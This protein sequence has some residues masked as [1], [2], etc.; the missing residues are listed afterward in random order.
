[1]DARLNLVQRD[2]ADFHAN[3]IDAV[4]RDHA[5]GSLAKAALS[6]TEIDSE[7]L[8]F[9]R[10]QR[11]LR[12]AGVDQHGYRATV[13]LALRHKIALPICAQT[14]RRRSARCAAAEMFADREIL[15]LAADFNG[16]R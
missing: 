2:V 12:R 9:R 5:D 15:A 4:H 10:R 16:G 13:D 1:M 7:P 6:L 3:E 11:N 8:C 14:G